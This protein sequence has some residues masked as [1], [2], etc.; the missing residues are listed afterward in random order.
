MIA[1]KN[2]LQCPTDDRFI[3]YH[4]ALHVIQDIINVD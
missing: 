4:H 2:L 1:N 3:G